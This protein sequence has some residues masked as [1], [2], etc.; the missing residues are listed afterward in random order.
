VCVCVCVCVCVRERERERERERDRERLHKY[1]RE[2]MLG[3]SKSL[4]EHF[5]WGCFGKWHTFNQYFSDIK[6]IFQV[7]KCILTGAF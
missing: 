6:I 3:S 7:S 4:E 1:V 5:D 2:S